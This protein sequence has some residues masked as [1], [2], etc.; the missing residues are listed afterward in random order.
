LLGPHPICYSKHKR[1]CHDKTEKKNSS[2]YKDQVRE[3][4]IKQEKRRIGTGKSDG[5]NS[6][7]P[8]FC[9]V[10][11]YKASVVLDQSKPAAFD[12]SVS[13]PE[14]H[15]QKEWVAFKFQKLT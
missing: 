7:R 11:C 5:Q 9:T 15:T 2:P 1:Y 6:K 10:T 4:K 3:T 12:Q 14:Q 13:G 8:Y